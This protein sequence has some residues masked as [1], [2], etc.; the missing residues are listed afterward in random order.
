M[1]LTSGTRLGPYEILSPL[2]AGGM[3]EVYRARDTRLGRDVAVK[4]LPQHLSSNSEVRAR[5]ERE[6]KTVSSLNHPNICTLFDVGREADTDF[7]VMELVEGETLATRLERGALPAPEVLKIGVQVADALSRAHRAGVIHRDLKPGNIMLTRSGAKLMDFGLARATGL[8]GP[9]SGSGLTAMTHSPTIAQP[10]TAEGTIVG[11][12][13]YM[14]PEQLEGK[15]ADTRSDIWSLGCVLYEM[16]TGKRPF[17]GRSQAS[18]IAAILEHEPAPIA[19]LQPMS[20]PAL[21]RLVRAMLAKDPDDRVQTAQDAKLQLEW[22][23]AEGSLPSGVMAAPATKRSTRRRW[24]IAPLLLVVGAAAFYAGRLSLP[25]EDTSEMHFERK[26]YRDAAIFVARFVRDSKTIVLSAATQ[27]NRTR[28]YVIRPDYPEPRP[29]GADGVH[30]LAVS[31]KGELA[32]LNHARYSGHHRLFQGTLARTPLE[33]AAPRDVMENVREADWSPDGESLAVIHE[34]NGNDHLEYPI[35]KVLVE[36]AGYLSDIRVSPRGDHIAYM[37][38]PAKWDDRGSVNVV[39]L[40]G[41]AEILAGGYWGMEGMAWSPS[42]RSVFFSATLNGSDYVVH[43]VDL[44]GKLLPARSSVGMV[45]IHDIAPDGTWVVTRDDI[46]IRLSL[47][48]ADSKEDVDISWLANTTG[49]ILS[50]DGK[51]LCFTDESATA[52]PNYAV[53]I[54]STSGGDVI[55]L[56]EGSATQFSSDGKSILAVVFSTPPRIV[57]YPVGAGE[58]VRLDGGNF[59]NVSDARWTRDGHVLV[60]ANEAG[61]PARS[62]LLDPSSHQAQPVGADGIWDCAPSPDGK[63]F[64]ARSQSGWSVFPLTGTGEGRP[65]PSMTS[66]DYVMQWSPDGT[67]VYCFHRSDVPSAVDRI[68]V[69]TGQRTTITTVGDKE[70]PGLV[71]VLSATMSEDLHTLVYGTLSDNSIL[72]TAETKK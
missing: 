3:G 41:H 54:R 2:G 59:E 5:F 61:K 47:R 16:T 63:V 19:S 31:S 34:V 27:G 6:A 10:L 43:E 23:R 30:L 7:L 66:G 48:T 52:G 57:S 29:I 22:V 53:S 37:E 28:L 36:S 42:G 64:I 51:T 62:F 39:D 49:P 18:L 56:G 9:G 26:T 67:A 8:A 60:S 65:V 55:R 14:A 4:V 68:D 44:K 25:G 13:Q 15:E 40:N 1:S 72:Y 33:G 70:R 71:S 11:T 32:V 17:E 50:A 35:G 20:P 24:M 69:A 46:P 58:A 21:D 45:V 38:H 12:F